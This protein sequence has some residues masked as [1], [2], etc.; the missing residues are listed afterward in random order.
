MK[1]SVFL[2]ALIP[3]VAPAQSPAYRDPGMKVVTQVAMVCRDIEA[4]SLTFAIL[5][6]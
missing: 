1:I 5:T 4:T 3:A 6:A 2:L